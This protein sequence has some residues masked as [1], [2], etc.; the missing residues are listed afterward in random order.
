MTD[1]RY[2]LVKL[3]HRRCQIESNLEIIAIALGK[4]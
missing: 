3:K 2:L 4:I 1:N